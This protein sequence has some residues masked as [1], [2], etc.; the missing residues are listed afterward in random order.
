MSFKTE[1]KTNPNQIFIG[2]AAS[3]KAVIRLEQ[4]DTDEPMLTFKGYGAA[5]DT[6]NF[7]NDNGDGAVEG[8]KNFSTNAGWAYEGMVRV[9]IID[10][11]AVIA[12][13]DYWMPIYSRDTA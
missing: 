5:D 4:E 3:A 11:N 1:A 8:P 2:P 6:L 7:S 9:R 10:S 12:E 13:A